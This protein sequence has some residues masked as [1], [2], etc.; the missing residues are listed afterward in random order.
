MK[1]SVACVPVVPLGSLDLHLR[2]VQ[3]E[4]KLCLVEGRKATSTDRFGV[5]VE[6]M[7]RKVD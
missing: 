7:N 5:L 4:H 6:L 1:Q 3:V 2:I